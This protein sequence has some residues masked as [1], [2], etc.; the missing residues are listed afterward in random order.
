MIR[1]GSDRCFWAIAWIRWR[2]METPFL[3]ASLQIVLGGAL[4]F[5]VGILIGSA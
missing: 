1:A 4:V 3:R 2:Y 5:A